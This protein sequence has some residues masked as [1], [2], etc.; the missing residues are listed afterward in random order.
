MKKFK[1]EK[2]PLLEKSIYLFSLENR[3][4][5]GAVF[6]LM[7]DGIIGLAILL[8]IVS[9]LSYFQVLRTQ[10]ANEK[11]YSLVESATNSPNG[12]V[13]SEKN[14]LLTPGGFSSISIR[15]KTN[16]YEGCFDFQS[17]LGSAKIAGDV[18]DGDVEVITFNNVVETN[19]YVQCAIEN[20]SCDPEDQE[21]CKIMCIIS[22]GKKLVDSEN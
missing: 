10:A 21:C 4:Q 20:E 9:A 7:I 15:N 1:T 22:F 18:D 5:S 17:N 13:F 12:K 16:I 11:F 14:L 3:A 19:V 2:K 6:R 8:I